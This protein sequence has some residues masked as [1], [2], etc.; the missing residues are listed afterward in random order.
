MD[1]VLVFMQISKQILKYLVLKSAKKNQSKQRGIFAL[2]EFW[3][4]LLK[5]VTSEQ[6]LE[7]HERVN[8]MSDLG[9]VSH[10]E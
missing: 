10:A 8:S 5:E 1:K 2:K 7:W 4:S 3:D 9:R 6:R